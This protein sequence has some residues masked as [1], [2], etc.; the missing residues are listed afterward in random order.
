MNKAL[1]QVLGAVAYGELKAYEGAKAAAP[2]RRR[3]PRS[4]ASAVR[5]SCSAR[6]SEATSGACP[7]SGSARS[8]SPA[9]R[10]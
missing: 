4:C 2:T 9:F 7:P 1:V 5:T 3:W 8:G 10:W 6:S